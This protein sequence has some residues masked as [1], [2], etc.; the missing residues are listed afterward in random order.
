[1]SSSVI[2]CKG[3]RPRGGLEAIGHWKRLHLDF[4]N[5]KYNFFASNLPNIGTSHALGVRTSI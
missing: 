2:L 4:P 3:G 5:N 1:M